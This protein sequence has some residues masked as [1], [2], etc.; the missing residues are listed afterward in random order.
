M[1]S[2]HCAARL[3]LGVSGHMHKHRL[4]VAFLLI[5][6]IGFFQ[7]AIAEQTHPRQAE[8][9][10]VATEWL[11]LLDSGQSEESFGQL[12]DIFKGNLTETLWRDQVTST[13]Q[14]LGALENRK[15]RRVVVYQDPDNA[16]LPGTYVAVEFDSSYQHAA[17]HF[18][19]VM[20]HSLSGEPFKVMRHEQT[21]ALNDPP[22]DSGA[23]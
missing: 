11:D 2:L 12:T 5:A 22:R 13:K 9:V 23:R 14:T 15:V 18:Q 20:L 8:A 21:F 6:L 17:V 7:T 16:P 19:Y 10:Q 4:I 3:N 1:C